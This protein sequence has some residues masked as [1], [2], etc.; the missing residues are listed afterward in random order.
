MDKPAV[1]IG[2]DVWWIVSK[3][4]SDQAVYD[5]LKVIADP[6]NL[7]T[8]ASTSGYWKSL[9]GKFD[10]LKEHKI[11]VHPAAA[12]YWTEQGVKVPDE[13]VKGYQSGT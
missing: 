8:L 4:M 2:Y 11:Y 5:I 6:K 10:S 13:I 9:T 3:K 12:K 1:A 7:K